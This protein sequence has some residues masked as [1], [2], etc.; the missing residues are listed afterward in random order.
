MRVKKV[1][2]KRTI[3]I[4]LAVLV[5]ATTSAVVRRAGGESA[6]PAPADTKAQEAAVGAPAG[7]PLQVVR[8]WIH[9][10]DLYPSVVRVRPGRVVLAAQNETQL[11]VS[12]VVEKVEAGNPRQSVTRLPTR[13]REKRNKQELV[14][15]PGEYEFYCDGWPEV[16]GR[17]IVDPQMR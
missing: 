17:L 5:L 15:A 9:G 16:R 12:L 6:K 14:L 4:G 7:L 11:D 3:L 10:D 13:S 8:I 1:A 2:K